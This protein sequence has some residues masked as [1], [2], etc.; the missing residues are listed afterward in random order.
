MH[1]VIERPIPQ[2]M[3]ATSA[4]LRGSEPFRNYQ[5]E[6]WLVKSLLVNLSQ[7]NR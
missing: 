5:V 3:P 2:T 1:Q 7:V 4:Y 6:V